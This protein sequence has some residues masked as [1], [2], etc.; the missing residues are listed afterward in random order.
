VVAMDR[1]DRLGIRAVSGSSDDATGTPR[2][3]LDS[4]PSVG[5]VFEASDLQRGILQRITFSV[6]TFVVSV[7]IFK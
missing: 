5:T 7:P 2:T 6:T 4:R 3:D 1:P